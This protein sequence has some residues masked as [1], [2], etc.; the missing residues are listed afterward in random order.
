MR[1]TTSSPSM[2]SSSILSSVWVSRKLLTSFE[3]SLIDTDWV[4][5]VAAGSTIIP[6][7]F[8]STA[9]IDGCRSNILVYL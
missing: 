2:Y 3:A 1:F 6:N 5:E 9:V 8:G 4:F 7:D